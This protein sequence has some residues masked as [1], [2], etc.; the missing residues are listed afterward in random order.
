VASRY[1]VIVVGAGPAGSVAALE[2]VRRGLG[3]VLLLEAERL[4]RPKTCGGGLS[5]RAR[6]LLRELGLWSQIEARAY[7]IKG[8][9][10][11]GPSGREVKLGGVESASVLARGELDELLA[12]QAAREGAELRE[13]TRVE[14]LALESG[15]VRGV[16]TSEG[17]IEGRWVVVA[18][19]AHSKLGADPRPRRLLQTC[20]AWYE[21]V[22]FTPNL[23]EMVYD[24]ELVPHYGWLFPES[25]RRVNI[26]LCVDEERLKGSVRDLFARF[27]ERHYAS[28]L[29]AATQLGRWSG[30]PISVS[31][32]VEHHAAPGSLVCGEACRLVNPATGE[33]IAYAMRSGQL[34][35]EAIRIA[36]DRGLDPTETARWYGRRLRAFIEPGLRLS[37]LYCRGGVDVVD[38]LTRL[39]NHSLVNQITSRVLARL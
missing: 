32:D 14:R 36:R 33:G 17:V 18:N 2:A 31:V 25:E 7:P 1:E 8:M 11:V 27:L 6:K 15:R 16:V 3:P 13:G 10:L 22:P 38:K 23:V 19:G 12:R 21:G 35:A 29:A 39:A 9:R 20:M 24:S 4:P 26:G 5:P 30:H 28:R 34:A 37:S